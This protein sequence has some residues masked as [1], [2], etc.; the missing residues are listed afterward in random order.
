MVSAAVELPPS[1]QREYRKR[2]LSQY[3]LKCKIEAFNAYGK[4]ICCLCNENRIKS[5]SIDHIN[6][7]GC[8][9]R[10][11][12]Y[13]RTGVNLYAWLRKMGYPSGFRVLCS[14]CNW[15]AYLEHKDKTMLLSQTNDAIKQR[16]TFIK[17]K[18]KIINILGNKCVICGKNDIRILTIH[19]VDFNGSDHR[20]AAA[21][22]GWLKYYR[23]ILQTDLA[24]LE[25]RCFSCND[26]A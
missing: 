18:K 8:K 24:G 16:K 12:Q 13:R 21:K 19:H 25:C 23:T 15:L 20:R 10:K 9:Q 3:Y 7:D 22:F 5:L 14:N 26:G 4:V 1:H 2:Y 6:Q 17:L 11:Q